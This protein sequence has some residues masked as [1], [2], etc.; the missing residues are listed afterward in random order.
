MD[1]PLKTLKIRANIRPVL[2]RQGEPGMPQYC[3]DL[4]FTLLDLVLASII[5][6]PAV[7]PY[8]TFFGPSP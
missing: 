2:L 8:E 1:R 7:C 6:I 5:A 3:Y 4:A